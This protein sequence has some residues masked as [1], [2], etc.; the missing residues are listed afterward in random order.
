MLLIRLARKEDHG[1]IWQILEPTIRAGETYALPCDM[2]EDDGLIYWSGPDRQTFVAEQDGQIASRG[3]FSADLGI[4]LSTALGACIGAPVGARLS[5]FVSG[6]VLR[7]AG[8][9]ATQRYSV[10]TARVGPS[11]CDGAP[12]NV[13]R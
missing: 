12:A 2:S 13:E 8:V 9:S 6:R 10:F 11:A 5:H 3:V 4:A 7:R 1:A